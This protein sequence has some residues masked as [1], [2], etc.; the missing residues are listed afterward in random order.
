MVERPAGDPSGIALG[1]GLILLG[2]WFLLHNLGLVS[3]KW[4]LAWPLILVALGLRLI[5][6]NRK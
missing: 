3:F 4:S 6:G 5:I 1:I 2:V